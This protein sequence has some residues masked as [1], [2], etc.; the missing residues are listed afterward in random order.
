MGLELPSPKERWEHLHQVWF[1]VLSKIEKWIARCLGSLFVGVGRFV[2]K[3]SGL[4]LE[5]IHFCCCSGNHMV[6]QE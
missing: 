1:E 2:L 3:F 5:K 4:T 6:C